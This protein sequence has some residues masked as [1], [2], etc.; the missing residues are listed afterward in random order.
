MAFTAWV[1]SAG[2]SLDGKNANLTVF[3]KTE[4]TPYL[5]SR[6]E[7]KNRHKSTGEFACR[8]NASL[9]GVMFFCAR[10]C[11][12]ITL[13]AMALGVGAC[14]QPEAG[15]TEA[16]RATIGQGVLKPE[17]VFRIGVEE[18][19]G[20]SLAVGGG[21]LWTVSDRSGD[22]V[23]ITLD[24]RELRRLATGFSD[25]EAIATLDESR[26]AVV[27]ERTREVVII[28]HQGAELRRASLE[29]AGSDN[30]GLEGLAYDRKHQKFYVLKEK[31]PG[32][33]LVLDLNM[34]ELSRHELTFA[35]DFSS[36]D[37]DPVR[38]HLWVMSDESRSIHVLGL[39]L[40]PIT[41]FAIDIQQA[42]GLAVDY[43][44][45]RLYVVS[46]RKEKLYVYS[47]NEY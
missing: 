38:K 14:R 4:S 39:D 23:E 13:V 40:K 16:T 17:G 22:V 45:R 30:S 27:L 11:W 44:K 12:V 26:L 37:F 28:D 3:Y 9:V 41:S 24:G 20:L 36:I 42:E 10:G 21:S 15:R 19:S 33:L 7:C 8:R 43:E 34:K 25:V 6:V 31:T 29:L 1:V 35:T 2:R 47:F 18:P 46:D 5:D 32:L